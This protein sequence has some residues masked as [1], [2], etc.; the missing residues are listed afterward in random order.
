MNWW[1]KYWEA[2]SI[3]QSSAIHKLERSPPYVEAEVSLQRSKCS[4][5][6]FILSNIASTFSHFN[7]ILSRRDRFYKRAM[8]RPTSSF[9]ILHLTLLIAF[10]EQ[11]L[12]LQFSQPSCPR[13]LQYPTYWALKI[14]QSRWAMRNKCQSVQQWKHVKGSYWVRIG[15]ASR[16]C[17]NTRWGNFGTQRSCWQL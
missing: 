11:L 3:D 15:P 16:I 12:S 4:P 17:I 7:I 8:L 1:T 13:S 2:I 6:I 10:G 9:M 5:R 14:P